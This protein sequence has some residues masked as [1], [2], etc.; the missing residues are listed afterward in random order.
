MSAP[1]PSGSAR[2]SRRRPVRAGHEPTKTEVS[3]KITSASSIAALTAAGG[4]SPGRSA[5]R[6]STVTTSAPSV[7]STR[8]IAPVISASAAVSVTINPRRSSSASED[9]TPPIR[10]H[11]LQRSIHMSSNVP[12][13][14]APAP[15]PTVIRST[16]GPRPRRRLGLAR[17]RARVHGLPALLAG[18]RPRLQPS[19]SSRASNPGMAVVLAMATYGVGYLARPR[20]RL[21]L[22]AHGRQDRPQEGAVLHDPPHGPGD[23]ADRLPAD[24]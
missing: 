24:V 16:G 18:G 13:V 23:D 4:S 3:S 21:L 14:D 2:L 15:P 5:G 11:S 12:G 9:R 8:A 10:P 22:R 1:G 6:Y 19:C 20:R 7:R 17:H